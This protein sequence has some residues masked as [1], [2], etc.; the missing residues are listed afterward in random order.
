MLMRIYV[1][2]WC[3]A[4]YV[5]EIVLELILILGDVNI[6]EDL[7]LFSFECA[8]LILFVKIRRVGIW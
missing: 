6:V 5:H 7:E 4:L 8:K 1:Y 3:V 2:D